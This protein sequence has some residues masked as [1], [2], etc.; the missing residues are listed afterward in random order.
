MK[1]DRVIDADFII[2]LGLIQKDKNVPTAYASYCESGFYLF[3]YF[4]EKLS[5]NFGSYPNYFI[6]STLLAGFV[7][8]YKIIPSSNHILV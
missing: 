3:T 4:C 8:F 6:Q 7:G 2:F 1:Y 5:F